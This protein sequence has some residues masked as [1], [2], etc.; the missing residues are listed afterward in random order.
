[1]INVKVQISKR[2]CHLDFE[3]HLKQFGILWNNL[4]FFTLRTP[5][6]PPHLTLL[7][8]RCE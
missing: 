1:M 5:H 8:A 6:V 4:T 7:A 3:I 2:F